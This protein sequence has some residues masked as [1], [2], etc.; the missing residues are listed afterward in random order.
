M[1]SLC[2]KQDSFDK[3]NLEEGS[4]KSNLRPAS[5]MDNS[6]RINFKSREIAIL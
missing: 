5:Y 4:G 2:S 1:G 3:L 6:F